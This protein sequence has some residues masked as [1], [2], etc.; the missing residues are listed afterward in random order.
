MARTPVPGRCTALLASLA[1]AVLLGSPA[2]AGPSAQ[3]RFRGARA[4]AT[5]GD[6]C[7]ADFTQ[8]GTLSNGSVICED[9]RTLN[10]TLVIPT[11]AG[12]LTLDKRVYLQNMPASWGGF[13]KDQVINADDDV[14]AKKFLAG[15]ADPDFE[16]VLNTVSPILFG[17]GANSNFDYV[18]Q[19]TFV[20]SRQSD[21]QAVFDHM[22]DCGIYAGYPRPKNVMG[23][24]EWSTGNGTIYEGLMGSS[25]LVLHFAY[26][27][28]ATV[29]WEMT[30]VPHDNTDGNREQPVH[31][32]FA[33]VSTASAAP[34]V[35]KQ[36]FF[37]TYSYNPSA[38][39]REEVAT[40][41]SFYDALVRHH[42]YW[43]GTWE[44]EQKMAITGV[45]TEAAQI[46]VDQSDHSLIRDMVTR[47]DSVW[48]RYG[49]CGDP[50]GCAYGGPHNNG[51]E[52]TL[53]ASV[54]AALEWGLHSYATGVLDNFMRYYA[55]R[56]GL[57]HYRGVEMAQHARILTITA[58]YYAY[59]GNATMVTAFLDKTKGICE[60]LRERINMSRKAY[61]TSSPMYGM[62]TGNDE[63]DLWKDYIEMG[64]AQGKTE[65]PFY[66]IAS[67]TV[68]GFSDFG[69]VLQ[70]LVPND[71]YGDE[72]VA[73]SK[74]LQADF[75]QSLYATYNLSN[76]SCFGYVAGVPSC[77][78]LPQSVGPSIRDSEPWRTYAEMYYSDTLPADVVASILKW[79]RD[80]QKMMRL[81]MLSGSGSD[82]CGNF[83]QTFTSHGW[84]YGLISNGYI[85]EFLMSLYTLS[86]HAYTRGSWTALEET[87]ID[88]LGGQPYCP[89][90]Q[91]SVPL[92]VKWMV[93]FESSASNALH[94]A[95]G[96]PRDWF[97]AAI[98][99]G[100]GSV[101]SVAHAPSRFGSVGYSLSAVD[102]GVK[103]V[104]DKLSTAPTTCVSVRLPLSLN[105]TSVKNTA[106]G[107]I[108]AFDP[109][110]EAACFATSEVSA[111]LS[112]LFAYKQVV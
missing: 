43:S 50:G 61:P 65:L 62:P 39:A 91:L 55:R 59:T 49:V 37:D 105:V 95:K 63:A 28:N 68:R 72:L 46:L 66:S 12:P 54:T 26:Q 31:F 21:V 15:G 8:V 93:L 10:G 97:G 89:V 99:S 111:P 73:E 4:R 30:I 25:L 51:F 53:T 110:T 101:L 58:K 27:V 11:D 103:F 86:N 20:S 2:A 83:L 7:S 45:P 29:R 24:Q 47:S 71:P 69:A 106:S 34:E 23:I 56:H 42:G 75:M 35:T 84:S 74:T 109:A 19:H 107:K 22:G 98:A 60:L 82:C 3:S 13:T 80:N 14:L 79:N 67:E 36:V 81:G 104:A 96:V 88:Y 94:Y 90:A 70:K 32:R 78:E 1:S 85:P 40:G 57:I 112:L 9:F 48:P 38:A 64:A 18:G 108:M 16:E 6:G 100:G 44:A 5:W 33:R 17:W 92:S 76:K 77:A 87:S 41:R 52:E 102:G